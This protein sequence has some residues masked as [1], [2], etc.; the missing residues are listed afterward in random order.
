[1]SKKELKKEINR[2]IKSCEFN[3]Q[4]TKIAIQDAQRLIDM[5]G[6]NLKL[7]HQH[8]ALFVSYYINLLTINFK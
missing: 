2:Q 8:D 4:Q 1:M 3:P 7:T 6:G 5:L